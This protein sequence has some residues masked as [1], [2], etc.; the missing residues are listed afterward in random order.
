MP[1][2]EATKVGE[3]SV[4]K[5]PECGEWCALDEVVGRLHYYEL[6]HCGLR[7]ALMPKFAHQ[8]KKNAK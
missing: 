8:G 3:V 4:G 6:E 2:V 7:Y 1:A 5:C